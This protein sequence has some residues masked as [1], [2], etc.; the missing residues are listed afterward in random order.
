MVGSGPDGSPLP[1]LVL[2]ECLGLLASVLLLGNE[3]RLRR[4]KP[5]S[6]TFV[7]DEKARAHD[8]RVRSLLGVSS[9]LNGLVLLAF[10]ATPLLGLGVALS[11]GRATHGDDGLL[12]TLVLLGLALAVGGELRL[13]LA[14][15][16]VMTHRVLLRYLQL[17]GLSVALL[18]GGDLA[19]WWSISL[20]AMLAWPSLIVG[21]LTAVALFLLLLWLVLELNGRLDDRR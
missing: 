14:G 17:K 21:G 11:P 20:G 1:A 6:R 15:T 8:A 12:L 9:F 13:R 4:L 19:E 3:E 7:R 18:A 5:P 10:A 2:A 16:R